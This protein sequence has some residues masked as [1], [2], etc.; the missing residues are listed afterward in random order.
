MRNLR[1]VRNTVRK[2]PEDSL[3]LT[4]TAWDTA[5]DSLICTFGPSESSAVIEL[6]RLVEG[7]SNSEDAFST[8]AS[9]DAPCPLPDLACDKV[10]SLQ[11]F[12]DT[13]TS[14]LILA[15]GD[16]VIVRE[17][18]L[19]GEDLI[20]IVGSVD[21]GI[22]AA[23][24]SPDEELLA[25]STR[26]NTLLY[27]TREFENVTSITLTPED[28]KAS[29]HV[30]VG[31]GK[32]E[33]QFQGKRAKALR[34]PTVPE[35]VDEGLLSSLDD[36]KVTITW[37]GDGA[38]LAVNSIEG[39][40]RRMIRVY[41]REGVL[42]SVSE[43]VDYLEG[44]L[45]WRPAGNLIAGIQRLDDRID[46]VFFERNGLRHGQFS[47]R[48]T[49]EEMAAWGS[50]I[51]LAWNSDSTVLAVSF[52]DR[53][54]LW[55]M[56]NYHYY[57]KQE[58]SCTNDQIA[59][60]PVE[61]RWNPE[62]AL[63][64]SVACPNISENLEFVFSVASCSSVQPHDFGTVAVVDGRALKVTPLRL[65]NIPPP[66]SRHEVCLESNAI[67][68]ATNASSTRIAVLHDNEVSLYSYNISEKFPADP[69]M[70]KREPL[71]V[72]G[73]RPRQIAFRGESEIFVLLDEE[74]T[75]E[76]VLCHKELEQPEF[77]I[78]PLSRRAQSLVTSVD[79]NKV[80]IQYADASVAP[81]SQDASVEET[82]ICK[83]PTR[84]AWAEVVHHAE[85]DI[86]VGLTSNG[87]LYANG[88]LLAKS[89]TSF[90][91]T[92]AHIIF[93]TT[94]HLLKFVH[95]APVD[96]LEVPLD[97]PERDERCR[98]IE[99]GAR[100]VT[101]MPSSFSVVLQMPRGNLETIFPRAMVVAGI[102]KN[103]A[104]K[105]YK[106]AFM[107]CRNQ[108]VDMNII[109]D[110]M[111][112]QFMASIQ[113]FIDQLK[114]AAHI[115]LFLSQ[116]RNEDV[117]QTMYKETVKNTVA[118][119]A[120]ATAAHASGTVASSSSFDVSTKVNRICGGFL[121]VLHKR[122]EA[123]LQNIVT[124]HV[125]KS[126]PDLE[127]GL[128]VVAK[129][130]AQDDGLAE[131]AAEHICFLA[132][133]NQLYDTALGLY[134]LEVALLV[135]QQSQKDPREYLPYVQ[136]LG[137]MSQL[138]RQ[139]TIDDNL[140][141]RSKALKHL[142]ELD[143]FDELN[144]YTEKHELYSDAIAL[145]KYQPERL[146][147]TM[148]LY[149][150]YLNSRNRFREA[151]IA[152]EYLSDYTSATEAYRAA[153]MWREA[154][155]SATSVPLPETEITSL[156]EALADTLTETKDFYAAATIHLDYLNDLEAATRVF[157][158]GYF[159]AEALRVVG[160]RR[161]LE[162]VESVIDPGLIEGSA[163][164]T[165]ML[166][167]CKGQL[168]AQVPRLR[169]LRQKKAEDPLAFYEGAGGG[170]GG[171]I[172]D[173]V[174]V[175]ATDTTSGGTF[176]TRYTNRTGTVN[177]TSTRRT[178]KNR[179]R[180]ERKR[181]RGKKGSVYEEEYLV[182]SIGRLIE[183]VNQI[184]EEVA[185]LVEGL[186]RRGM[187]ERAAAVE[188]IMA[189]VVEAATSSVEEVFQVEKTQQQQP[190]TQGEGAEGEA[191][192][193]ERP[194][195]ADGVLWDSMQAELRKKEAPVV[196]RFEKLSLVG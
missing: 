79:Y 157:C 63:R 10:L 71:Q 29:N 170:E 152:F 47:L 64:L 113:L 95:L 171:D 36:A 112:E 114:K 139:F 57:L 97:E 185:R 88:R 62:K 43:P 69:V 81:I 83:F 86:A 150:A 172:P 154:L 135:A 103:I 54:Q 13:L 59:S 38:Y 194:A 25:I 191:G 127:G 165:E 117:T 105:K 3:P 6:K 180:E 101:V 148:A 22:S 144:L 102:R 26:A 35:K 188:A 14:C 177:T 70:E 92:L 67:D 33:T 189:D 106:A 190:T 85:E 21:A 9:W 162:L 40:K 41:S 78:L 134:N 182:S 147:E 19:P 51:S 18:P 123:N 142:H 49:P 50:N 163:A 104:D 60:S 166:A 39:E 100:L 28:I 66:M 42:D 34:D 107:A 149:A 4:A 121:E 91:V 167:E 77:S 75:G 96:E 48:L 175:A 31:W 181:A 115:D 129:A 108:R 61:A 130:K 153:N 160:L 56:G 32:R 137:E 158:K 98:A 132:D 80:C 146:R 192:L 145:H 5:T 90:R 94:Q 12:P 23:A 93:T 133:V 196:K 45:S 131:K 46:V 99:R 164:M 128:Q 122:T 24:W 143:T 74:D 2:F 183:R 119:T 120:T 87:T 168:G 193:G 116:L 125:C 44:A 84:V 124:A 37:R 110:H 118:G 151:G 161:R 27:M 174:S 30:S 141:R 169:E 17:E 184:N 178:S 20:E 109:H 138:R 65:T 111:P 179:R 176:M 140:G 1:T 186:M 159:F 16:I 76:S 82:S 8:I 52:K 72:P 73:A 68:V 126:P 15:G 11:Y 156:A 136:G 187:R 89:C 55:T 53:V 58:I 195:G 7:G 173:N 155:F